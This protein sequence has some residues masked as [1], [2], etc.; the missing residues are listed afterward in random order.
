MIVTAGVIIA[1]LLTIALWGMVK[2]PR[3]IG[4]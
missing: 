3:K 1:I 2:G 4:F